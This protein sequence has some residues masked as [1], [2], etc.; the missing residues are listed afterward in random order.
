MDL[1]ISITKHSCKIP[2]KNVYLG[3]IKFAFRFLIQIKVKIGPKVS[4]Q[5][6][7]VSTIEQQL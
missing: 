3:N 4:V 7:F 6:C 2:E 5:A 1:T